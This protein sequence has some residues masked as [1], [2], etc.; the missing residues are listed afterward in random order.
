MRYSSK[1]QSFDQSTCK[2]IYNNEQSEAEG[3]KPIN[4][5]APMERMEWHQGLS[6]GND[7]L[8]R[9]HQDIIQLVNTLLE[10]QRGLATGAT[11]RLSSLLSSTMITMTR[12]FIEEEELMDRN[13]CPALGEHAKDHALMVLR[14]S[15]AHFMP[16][17][18][19]LLE[20]IPSLRD[21]LAMHF[22]HQDLACRPYLAG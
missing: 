1:I 4:R 8:D 12:H 16:E 7:R 19:I 14:L 21:M 5:G 11:S 3:G 17:E 20:R 18:E 13:G 22:S 6:T 10:Y 2:F 9:Q 15:E